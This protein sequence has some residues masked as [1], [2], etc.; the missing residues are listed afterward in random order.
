MFLWSSCLCCGLGRAPAAP[1]RFDRFFGVRVPVAVIPDR[2]ISALQD[3]QQSLWREM[4]L[5]SASRQRSARSRRCNRHKLGSVGCDQHS[6]NNSNRNERG[7]RPKSPFLKYLGC[8]RRVLHFFSDRLIQ[9]AAS[10]RLV[11]N[12]RVKTLAE[13]RE[14]PIEIGRRFG[15]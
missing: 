1:P 2:T 15:R 14:W 13:Y 4:G 10:K 3:F 12:N 11:S 6:R 7:R 8:D 5:L 9:A